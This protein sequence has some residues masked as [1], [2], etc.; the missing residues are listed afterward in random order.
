[1]IE[2][3]RRERECINWLYHI[4][5]FGRKKMGV[6]LSQGLSA[7]DIYCMSKTQ[8]K[9]FLQE[10]CGCSETQAVSSIIYMEE[11][12][13]EKTP[14]KLAEELEKK[15][16]LFLLP[17]DPEY[18]AKLSCIP[19]EPFCLYMKGDRK[20]AAELSKADEPIQLSF[21]TDTEKQ[22]KL[23]K[24]ETVKDA[25]NNRYGKYSICRAVLLSDKSLLPEYDPAG[26][27]SC[28]RSH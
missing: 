9:A 11:F 18:P 13:K 2:I 21:F 24:I 26:V 17:G 28:F 12:K 20:R 27:T 5:G 14:E 3:T 6:I 23:R 22:Q 15:E 7:E 16:I 8:A 10:R 4:K 1:M 25:I 19:D